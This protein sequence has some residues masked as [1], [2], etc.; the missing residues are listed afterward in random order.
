MVGAEAIEALGREILE[1]LKRRTGARGEGYVLWGLTPE[2]L[3]AS[4]EGLAK[5]VP[6]LAPRVPLYAER[7]RQGGFTLLVLLVGQGRSTW[8]A[9]RPP[10]SS[11]PGE[12]P[13]P[14]AH[15]HDSCCYTGP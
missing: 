12:W 9:R 11:C 8:W 4:L 7:I 3:I 2:E 10:W 13:E 15:P 6:A 14:G 1:A 5:E